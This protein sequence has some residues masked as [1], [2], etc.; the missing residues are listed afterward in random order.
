M[1]RDKGESGSGV[2]IAPIIFKYNKGENEMTKYMDGRPEAYNRLDV[3][4]MGPVLCHGPEHFDAHG[5][6]DIYVWRHDGRYFMHYDGADPEIGWLCCLAT[7]EDLLHWTKHGPVLNLGKAGES[8]CASASYGTV[9]RGKD[10]W[11]MFYLGTPNVTDKP[12]CVPAFPYLTKKAYGPSPYGPWIKQ[13]DAVPFS[14]V[15]GT[16]YSVCASP[17]PIL[18]HEGE[19]IQFF[20]AQRVEETGYYGRTLAIARTKDLDGPWTVDETPILPLGEQVENISLYFEN[21]MWYLFTNHIGLLPEDKAEYT[22]AIWMYWSNDLNHWNSANK[23]IVLDRSN[24]TWSK[25]IIGLPSV[26]PF[27]NRLA[28]FYDGAA[29]ESTSHCDRDIGLAFLELPI[30]RP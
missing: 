10:Q 20:S 4:D 6:R 24:C 11:H 23:A 26:V 17:G 5:A 27:G 14:P 2:K 8:D 19:Y 3:Q 29:G 30:Q 7:S 12:D 13:K 21:G 25:R 28:I 9:Y 22:D 15:P 16:Y 1:Q 18:R